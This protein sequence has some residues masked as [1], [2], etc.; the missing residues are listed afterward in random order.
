MNQIR[1]MLAVALMACATACA[2]PIRII[3]T[4]VGTTPVGAGTVIDDRAMYAAE[5]L[6]NVPAQAYVAGRTSGVIT[7]AVRDVVRPKLLVMRQ[8]L[9]AAR[10]AYRIGDVSGFNARVEALRQLRSEVAVLI[11]GLAEPG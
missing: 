8:T 5:A 9:L 6:Y 2:T 4:A 3:E 10:A 1:L 11:P 7:D